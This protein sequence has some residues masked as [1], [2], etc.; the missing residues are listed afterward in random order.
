[1]ARCCLEPSRSH[2]LTLPYLGGLIYLAVI[3]SVI[4]FACYLTLLGRIG[5]AR[6]GYATV[7]FPVAALLVSTVLEDFT[8][9]PEALT[10]LA[11]VIAGNLLVLRR[12]RKAARA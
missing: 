8:W 4:A 5:S 10:G 1:M 6:A 11:C 7:M 2:A 12:G 9:G 3:A